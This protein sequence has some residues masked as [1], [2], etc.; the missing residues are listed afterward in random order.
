MA[1]PQPPAYVRAKL[2]LEM[3]KL[4]EEIVKLKFE[5]SRPWLALVP[6]PIVAF[7][8]IA[9]SA[10]VAWVTARR[11]RW[12]AFDLAL[13]TKR[14]E[15]YPS[16]VAAT[17][18][19]AL[20]FP[21]VRLSPASCA[22]AG[23]ELRAAYFGGAGILISKEVRNTYFDLVAALTRAAAAP[24]LAAP[25]TRADYTRWISAPMI[26]GYRKRL[27]E[28]EPRFRNATTWEFGADTAEAPDVARRFQDFVVLQALASDLRTALTQ[29][30]GGRRRPEVAGAA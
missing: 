5:T 11:T 26:D 24:R 15:H 30:I 12:S 10:F 3:E 6:G 2:D 19:M 1:E 18:P 7:T 17:E 20:Y 21:R 27:K 23:D 4:R 13:Y 8:G 16:L 9:A 25:T 14:L 29:D 28:S 22:A